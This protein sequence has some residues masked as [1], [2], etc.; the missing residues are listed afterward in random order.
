MHGRE[1]RGLRAAGLLLNR[2]ARGSVQGRVGGAKSRYDLTWPFC[3][4]RA[5]RGVC[6][7]SRHW[8]QTF[9]AGLKEPFINS[10]L[11]FN[12]KNANESH[13]SMFPFVFLKPNLVLPFQIQLFLM[14][15]F[16]PSN[17]TKRLMML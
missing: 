7:E 15:F 17:N 9:I 5:L 6:R 3:A 14:F 2:S 4:G 8:S 12:R 16:P 11:L 1:R 13:T 10:A